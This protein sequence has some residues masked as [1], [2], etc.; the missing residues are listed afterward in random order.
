MHYSPPYELFLTSYYI[1]VKRIKQIANAFNKQFTNTIKH[2]ASKVV[3]RNKRQ[4]KAAKTT[5]Q[6]GLNIRHLKHL[7]P[8]G[9]NFLTQLHTLTLNTNIIPQ[10]WKPANIIPIPKQRQKYRHLIQTNFSTIYTSR[11][12]RENTLTIHYRQHSA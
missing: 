2:T 12:N 3:D 7:C 4:S 1:I 6:Q 9:L 11:N 10:V 5:T 8:L